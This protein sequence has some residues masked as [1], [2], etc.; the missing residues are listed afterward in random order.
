MKVGGN[1]TK[2]LLAVDDTGNLGTGNSGNDGAND[3][4]GIYLL[5]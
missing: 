5:R 1:T 3:R 4:Y 2:G